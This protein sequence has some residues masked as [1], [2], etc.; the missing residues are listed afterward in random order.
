MTLTQVVAHNKRRNKYQANTSNHGSSLEK[1]HQTPSTPPRF[2]TSQNNQILHFNQVH[3]VTLSNVKND[4]IPET[5][6]QS[7]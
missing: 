5:Y 6:N 2:S 3:Q 4:N 1:M 7:W